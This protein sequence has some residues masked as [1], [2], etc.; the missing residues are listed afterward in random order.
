MQILDAF[1]SSDRE[2]VRATT[3]DLYEGVTGRTCIVGGVAIRYWL[4][5]HGGDM[6][7]RPFN[8]LDIVA[9]GPDDFDRTHVLDRF[10]VHHFHTQGDGSDFR[11]LLVHKDT[12]TK[13]DVFHWKPETL[14]PETVELDGA[15]YPLQPLETQLAVT[16]YDLENMRLQGGVDP[17]QLTDALAMA[18]VADIQRAE[19]VWKSLMPDSELTLDQALSAALVRVDGATFLEKPW[20]GHA[21]FTCSKC[22]PTPEWPL[23]SSEEIER[24]LG[25]VE[26]DAPRKA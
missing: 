25:Y 19:K 21:P 4:A 9:T 15:M 22:R 6:P 17:K 2:R 3:L 16:V 8:D 14:V 20:Q 24:R 26:L 23:A 5:E 7:T 12:D 10:L 1:P 18:K 11:I 13:V